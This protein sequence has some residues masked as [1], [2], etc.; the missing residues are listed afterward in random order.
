[1]LEDLIGG[2]REPL[3]IL[4]GTVDCRPAGGLRERR[5][6]LPHSRRGQAA[7]DGR[8]AW[9]SAPAAGVWCASCWRRRWC[10]RPSAASSACRSRRLA[11]PA[12]LRLAPPTIPRLDQRP[13]RPRSS[14]AFA[15]AAAFVS[16]LIFGLAPGPPLHAAGHCSARCARADAAPP[17][18][19]RVI[20]AAI[21]WSS[22]RPR[23]RWCCSSARACSRAASRG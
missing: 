22:R 9:R 21:C 11:L 2:V 16:A 19:R 1:M 18:V 13:P 12:L 23:W 20:A 5:Q 4:L 14:S 15:T 3:W 8:A 17:I 6:P 10:C 7:R